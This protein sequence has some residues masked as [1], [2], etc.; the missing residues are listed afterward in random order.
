MVERLVWDQKVASSN[1]ATPTNF[2]T[3]Y[4][5]FKILLK[6]AK[7][8]PLYHYT[9]FKNFAN[10]LKTNVLKG[11]MHP[12][13]IINDDNNSYVYVTRDYSRQ[14]ASDR[15]R[16]SIGLRLDQE[17]LINNY[18]IIP[19]QTSTSSNPKVKYSR[20]SIVGDK[21]Y[22]EKPYGYRW[23]AEE[24]IIGDIKNIKDYITGIVISDDHDINANLSMDEF[25]YVTVVDFVKRVMNDSGLNVP[26]IYKR[27]EIKL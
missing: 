7:T 21:V 24:K 19:S 14:L 16:E 10:I 12:N 27:K 1:P 8:A 9:P 3:T 13:Q 4:I 25:S 22:V 5:M 17:K 6:E 26:I 2:C 15:S 20:T 23:E 11:Y 18:K